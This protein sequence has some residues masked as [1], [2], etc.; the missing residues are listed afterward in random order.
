MKFH[1]FELRNDI[2]SKLKIIAFQ[3]LKMSFRSSNI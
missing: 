3:L 1:I 2:L